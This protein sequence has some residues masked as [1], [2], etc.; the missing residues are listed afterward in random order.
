[1]TKLINFIL[2]SIILCLLR[3]NSIGLS[4][5]SWYFESNAKASVASCHSLTKFCNRQ[6]NRNWRQ[7]DCW[8][9]KIQFSHI[10][11]DS[12]VLTYTASHSILH[13]APVHCLHLSCC[14]IYLTIFITTLYFTSKHLICFCELP[15]ITHNESAKL[16]VNTYNLIVKAKKKKNTHFHYSLAGLRTRLVSVRMQV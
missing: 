5:R 12:P 14:S 10:H 4:E 7:I 15:I 13:W 16:D 11:Q 6:C 9:D 1:M 3:K 2:E 8:S